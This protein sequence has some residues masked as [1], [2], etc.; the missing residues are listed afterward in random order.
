MFSLS[1]LYL[2]FFSAFFLAVSMA[3]SLRLNSLF[4]GSV[5]GEIIEREKEEGERK[6]REL[7]TERAFQ[8]IDR[9]G[10]IESALSNRPLAFKLLFALSSAAL[11]SSATSGNKRSKRATFERERKTFQKN[12]SLFATFVVDGCSQSDRRRKNETLTSM[13]RPLPFDFEIFSPFSST[14]SSVHFSGRT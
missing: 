4:A 13:V 12:V 2:T 14:V 9:V 1:F 6:E 10:S 7:E 3:L 8:S 11:G 5:E